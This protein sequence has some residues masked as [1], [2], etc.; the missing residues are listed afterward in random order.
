VTKKKHFSNR[1]PVNL[2]SIASVTVL[3]CKGK[4]TDLIEV[5]TRLYLQTVNRHVA[6][7]RRYTSR[8]YQ[9][10]SPHYYYIYT[11]KLANSINPLNHTVHYILPHGTF[12]N[13]A[14]STACT[15][16]FHLMPTIIN[17]QIF[18]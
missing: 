4:Q 9:Q 2:L 10:I 16:L 15:Y 7:N 6:N 11:K 17:K 5:T 1:R 8:F 3:F 18:S 12:R 13:Y 14:L